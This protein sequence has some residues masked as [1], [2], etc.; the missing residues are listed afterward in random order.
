M[1]PLVS[2]EELRK[3]MPRLS[4]AAAREYA[5]L[6]SQAMLEFSIVN[7][8]RR[9]AFLSTLCEESAQLTKW[10]ENL[11]YSA[12]RLTEVWPRRFPSL[13]AAAPYAHNPQGLAEKVYGGRMGNSKPG[14]GW[15]FRGR[16]PIQATGAEMYKKLARALK[17][18]ELATDPDSCLLDKLIGFRVSAWIFAVEKG[19]NSWADQ[20]RMEGGQHDRATL[21]EICER[22]NGGHTG[23]AERINYFR[24]AKQVLHNDDEDDNRPSPVVP[25]V[26]SPVQSDEQESSESAEESQ[27]ENAAIVSVEQAGPDLLG[28]AVSSDKAKAFGAKFFAKHGGALATWLGVM[29][30]LHKWG[31][32]V[33][34]LLLVAA[35]LWVLYHN[36]KQLAP[37]VI[38]WLK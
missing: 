12:S 3:L 32:V 14:D 18:P 25:P 30:E 38:K 24:I 23:L 33:V 10:T 28:A 34:V 7:K 35:G 15:K 21:T 13:A 19:C 27:A 2:P 11:S 37:H 31:V 16:F 4:P 20:L 5:P 36:R 22:I 26:A 1:K 8:K 6:A 9:C 29:Y 17:V